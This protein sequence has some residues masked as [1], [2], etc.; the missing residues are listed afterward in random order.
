M[1]QND[2][3]RLWRGK[4]KFRVPGGSEGQSPGQGP[5]GVGLKGQK[6]PKFAKIT[7]F[8]KNNGVLHPKRWV[9]TPVFACYRTIGN[10]YGTD[11]QYLGSKEGLV[12]I[13]LEKGK[14]SKNFGILSEF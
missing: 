1:F 7:L 11:N 5:T 9:F 10:D 6:F 8:G 4:P 13:F 2:L 12:V 14:F 3:K